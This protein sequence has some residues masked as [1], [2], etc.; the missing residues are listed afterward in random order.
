MSRFAVRDA[1]MQLD[2]IRDDQRIVFLS[3]RCDFPFDTS[4]AL[5]FAL[6]RTFCVPSISTLLDSTGEY[7]HRPRK[8][9]YDTSMI[10][11][12]LIEWGYDSD[13]GARAL[14][15]MNEAHG[16]YAIV[17]D[18]LL[19][20][21]SAITFGLIRWNERYGWRRMCEPERL[22]YFHFWRHV[23][24]RM[25]IKHIPTDYLSFECFNRDYEQQHYCFT[26]SSHRLGCAIREAWVS[27]HPRWAAP[28]VRHAMNATLDEPARNALGFPR[29]PRLLRWFMPCVHRLRSS[30]AR[31][32]SSRDQRAI[33][34]PASAEGEPRKSCD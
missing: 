13:R 4:R 32:R 5:E 26:A 14:Q 7:I 3:S 17:N 12:E 24:Q 30:M 22:G 33:H 18:D 27:R 19:Y 6:L 34:R 11:R 20:V 9:N 2:P 23:G 10:F 29:P 8:R 31:R 1:I 25:N 16:R 15:R 28:L 21:L